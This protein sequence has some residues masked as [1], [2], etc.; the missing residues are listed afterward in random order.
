[1]KR[2][3]ACLFVC[4][5]MQL[6]WIAMLSSSSNMS[7]TNKMK[8]YQHVSIVSFK[9]LHIKIERFVAFFWLSLKQMNGLILIVYGN[10]NKSTS[11]ADV[12]DS[13]FPFFTFKC[14]IS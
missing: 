5:A 1:M 3:D 4:L 10:C 11:M 12:E 6:T 8:V 13:L 7:K 9:H 14:I 2:Y